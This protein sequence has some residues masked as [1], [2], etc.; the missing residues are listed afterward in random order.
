VHCWHVSRVLQTYLDGHTDDLTSRRV[1]EHLDE[2]RRCGLQADTYRAIIDA[3]ARHEQPADE[4][5]DRLRAFGE[6][7]LETPPERRS[8]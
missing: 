2:C 8:S 1:R 5:V 3:L 4:P 6:A 7:L